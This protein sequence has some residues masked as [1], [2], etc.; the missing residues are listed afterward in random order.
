MHAWLYRQ[1]D[2][3]ALSS[4]F[5]LLIGA[6]LLWK[7][8]PGLSEALETPASETVVR[9]DDALPEP[10][11]PPLPTPVAKPLPPVQVPV[12][13]AQATQ[14]PTP[15]VRLTPVSEP[16]HADAAPA[17]PTPPP[18][19]PP[20]PTAPVAAAALPAPVTPPADNA[21]QARQASAQYVSQLRAYL[22]SIKRYPNSREARQ[23]RPTGVVK[24]WLYLDRSGQVLDA[25]IDTSSGTAL[26]DT[27]ALRTLRNGHYPAFPADAF[28]G[29]ASH[30]FV[31]PL[32]Y[33]V[34]GG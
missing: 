34:D 33:L 14:A 26:L 19:P 31:V 17:V 6:V 9:L 24:T 23:L 5:A 10:P 8:S 25:G 22:N 16:S 18:A 29:E 13:Q 27:E 3:V 2:P 11:P 1:R 4:S 12:P 30:R 32:E 21:A 28:A 20:L 15:Q 7:L